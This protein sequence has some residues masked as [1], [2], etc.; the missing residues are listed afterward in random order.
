VDSVTHL[1]ANHL[2]TIPN[3]AIQ[4]E[5]ANLCEVPRTQSQAAHFENPALE[6]EV[7]DTEGLKQDFARLPSRL[8]QPPWAITASKYY[9]YCSSRLV[10]L[11]P[12]RI[13]RARTD[14]GRQRK[15]SAFRYAS[16]R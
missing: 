5:L 1:A 13:V 12:Q 11:A 3:S 2:A 9:H 4:N 15:A 16:D 10:P 8:R 7:S 14:I 6:R